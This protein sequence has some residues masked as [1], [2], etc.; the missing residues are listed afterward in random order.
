M[1]QKSSFCVIGGFLCQRLKT[2][3]SVPHVFTT[4]I[5][6]GIS[7]TECKESV[8]HLFVEAKLTG[9]CLLLCVES[10]YSR[11]ITMAED[12]FEV[13]MAEG[14]FEDLLRESDAR[15][16]LYEAQYSD[17]QSREMEEQEAAGA[18]PEPVPERDLSPCRSET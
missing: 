6:G 13:E 7:L 11:L 16:N 3:V 12:S 18:R 4:P 14:D 5:W 17:K 15:G 1:T 2:T 9:S 8:S 10:L